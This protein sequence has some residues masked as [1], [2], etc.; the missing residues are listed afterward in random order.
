MTRPRL[1][2]KVHEV[3]EEGDHHNGDENQHLSSL[4]NLPFEYADV[5]A[6]CLLNGLG[7]LSTKPRHATAT[8]VGPASPIMVLTPVWLTTAWHSPTFRMEP[9]HI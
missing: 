2:N 6:A 4:D 7:C 1:L 8:K 3:E 5:L 9:D